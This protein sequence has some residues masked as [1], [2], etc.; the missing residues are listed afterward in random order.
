MRREP[1]VVG[2]TLLAAGRRVK[3]FRRVIEVGGET[4]EK[5]LVTFGRSVVIVPV[6]GD[7]RVVFVRQ[8]RAPIARWIIELPAGR[9]ERGEDVIAAAGRELLEETGY[10]AGSLRL[11]G[12]FYVSP[13]YSDEV[14]SVV[15]AEGLKRGSSRPEEGEILST[16]VM[17][18]QEYL[19]MA[20]GEVLDLKTVAGLLLY[21]LGR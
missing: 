4:F 7:G 16:V 17:S 12:A 13:G 20:G 5:D 18:P 6:L 14:M 11:I 21:L 2:D 9:V 3:L 8:W 1:R 10:T 15:V 19:G